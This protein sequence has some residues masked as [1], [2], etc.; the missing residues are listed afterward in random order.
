MT[1]LIEILDRADAINIDDDFIRYFNLFNEDE[2]Y[3]TADNS[4]DGDTF[5][6]RFTREELENAIFNPLH[7]SFD[8]SQDGEIY[9]LTAY[10]IKPI[11]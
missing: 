8:I 5:D 4:C 11:F 9:R 1:N 3:L 7:D 6:Y 2:E 10:M